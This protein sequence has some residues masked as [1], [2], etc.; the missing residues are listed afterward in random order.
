M[1]PRHAGLLLITG[2]GLVAALMSLAAPR[3]HPRP[4]PDGLH[5]DEHI[6][7][8]APYDIAP[9]TASAR[10]FLD[11]P[12]LDVVPAGTTRPRR[13]VFQALGLDARLVRDLRTTPVDHVVFLRW[14][15][16]PSYDLVCMTGGDD[17]GQG[18]ARLAE[19][20]RQVYGV[21]FVSRAEGH[22]SSGS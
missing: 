22:G 7:G 11:L 3:H 17:Y 18:A 14:Q 20:E 12:C 10:S 1:N 9:A 16:S 19:P 15:V 21:R 5:T 2:L 6:R 8:L 13:E 4:E